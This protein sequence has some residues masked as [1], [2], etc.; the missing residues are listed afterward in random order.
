MNRGRRKPPTE[1]AS[2]GMYSKYARVRC[3]DKIGVE[4]RSGTLA[5]EKNKARRDV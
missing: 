4:D 1:S 2:G 3:E 5:S